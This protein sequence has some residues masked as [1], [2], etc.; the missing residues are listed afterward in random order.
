M[1]W[2]D[3]GGDDSPIIV[4]TRLHCKSRPGHWKTILKDAKEFTDKRLNVQSAADMVTRMNDFKSAIGHT[5]SAWKFKKTDN[6]KSVKINGYAPSAINIKNGHYPFYRNLSAV[7]SE[8]ASEDVSRLMG[9][10]QSLLIN[11]DVAREYSLL[12]F[13]PETRHLFNV[14]A[15]L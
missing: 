11:S 6:L 4:V 14:A 9:L 10:T 15:D 13:M 5:G 1:N 3:V 2:K 7:T 8:T 12:P